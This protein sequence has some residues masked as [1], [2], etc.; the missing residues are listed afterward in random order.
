[1][2][3]WS[4]KNGWPFV[5]NIISICSSQAVIFVGLS[6]LAIFYL[7]PLFEIKHNT[8]YYESFQE[9]STTLLGKVKS[10]AREMQN[11]YQ[12]YYK[13]YIQALHADKADR[14]VI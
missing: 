6:L 14:L 5:E 4:F 8:Y 2:C 11:F 1:M 3:F 12:E 7:L 9:N 13:K 10:D